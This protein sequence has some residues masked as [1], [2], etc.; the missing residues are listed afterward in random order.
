MSQ[1]VSEEKQEVIGREFRFAY[2]IPAAS[3]EDP[4]YHFVKEQV[5]Y[6][7]NGEIVIK[8]EMRIVKDFKRPVLGSEP[9]QHIHLI[10]DF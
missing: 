6:R 9:V 3:P 7:I 10:V 2:H 1:P 5:H 4:D 8:P